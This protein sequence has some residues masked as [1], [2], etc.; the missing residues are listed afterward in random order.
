MGNLSDNELHEPP[1]HI[2]QQMIT[3]GSAITGGSNHELSEWT[4]PIQGHELDFGA[5]S[6]G[7]EVIAGIL[8]LPNLNGEMP[9]ISF[10]RHGQNH[11][12]WLAVSIQVHV[13]P[14]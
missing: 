7:S 10:A 1:F 6:H 12:L 14:G 9:K 13:Q 2:A 3:T 11:R 4:I 8:R 5:I